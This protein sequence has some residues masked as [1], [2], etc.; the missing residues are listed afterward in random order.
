MLEKRWPDEDTC[1]N[2]NVDLEKD[3]ENTLDET[4]DQR[5]S[6][7]KMETKNTFIL[8]IIKRK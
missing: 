3:I 5:I 8:R 7:W 4:C 6:F 1:V 2:E